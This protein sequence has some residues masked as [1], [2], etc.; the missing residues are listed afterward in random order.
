MLLPQMQ[1]LRTESRRDR[2][3]ERKQFA[4][5]ASEEESAPQTNVGVIVRSLK[6]CR[7]RRFSLRLHLVQRHCAQ[8][9]RDQPHAEQLRGDVGTFEQR[10]DLAAQSGSLGEARG[11]SGANLAA[12]RHRQQPFQKVRIRVQPVHQ[13]LAIRLRGKE[14]LVR[15]QR[16][17]EYRLIQPDGMLIAGVPS[18]IMPSQR[19]LQLLTARTARP[20]VFRRK[21]LLVGQSNDRVINAL[22]EKVERQR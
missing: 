10:S 3:G 7:A 19:G 17:L 13:L 12:I 22:A 14:G 16:I 8:M 2:I 5:F 18:N 9:M 21:R 1:G 20:A 15:A 11:Q 6:R 4:A